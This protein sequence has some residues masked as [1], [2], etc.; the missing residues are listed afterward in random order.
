M[1]H[2]Y[3]NWSPL[4]F[5]LKCLLLFFSCLNKAIKENY[6]MFFGSNSSLIHYFVKGAIKERNPLFA[7]YCLVGFAG[8]YLFNPSL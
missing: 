4:E 5:V 3:I 8:V 1:L 7:M 6:T 2:F